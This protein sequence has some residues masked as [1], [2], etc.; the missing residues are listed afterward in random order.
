MNSIALGFTPDAE[1]ETDGD[2]SDA[3]A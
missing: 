2:D 1:T 3:G